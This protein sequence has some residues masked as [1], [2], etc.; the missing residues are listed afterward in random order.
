MIWTIQKKILAGFLA[1]LVLVLGISV[2]AM[3]QMSVL[4][5]ETTQIGEG[6]LP[7]VEL[8]GLIRAKFNRFRTLQLRYLLI[9]TQADR[10]FT[11]DKL[12][13]VETDINKAMERLESLLVTVEGRR[14]FGEFKRLFQEYRSQHAQVQTLLSER[15]EGEARK[16]LMVD[17]LKT[18]DEGVNLLEQLTAI[19]VDGGKE[20]VASA[21]N[22]YHTSRLLMIVVSLIIVGLGVGVSLWLSSR[23]SK[24]LIR[25]VE[26][27]K[28]LSQGVLTEKVEVTTNDESGQL[29]NAMNEMTDYLK[30]MARISDRL[31]AGDLSAQVQPKSAQDTFGVSFKQMI[32]NLTEMAAV[33]D[34]IASGDLSVQV[35]PKS[36]RDSF[37]IS[38][39]QMIANLRESLS[40]IGQGSSQVA[41]TSAQVASIG[42]LS[43]T[44]SQTLSSSSEEIT[45]TVHEM[46]SSIRQVAS[47]AQNQSAAATQTSAAITQMVAGLRGIAENA[48]RLASL[49]SA[50]NNAAERG[51]YTL[52]SAAQKLTQ[53]GSSV[54]SAGQT[55]NR[56][57]ERAESIGNIVETIDDIADQ[58][59]LLALNAAIEAARAGEHGLGFA[60]VAD[61]VRKLAERSA[62]STKEIGTL[63]NSIQL[64]SR[65]AVDQMEHSNQTVKEYM[66][67]SS[68]KDALTIIL[69]SAQQI[70]IATQE[71]ETA[72]SEQSAGAEQVAKAAQDL[73]R[74]TQEIHAATDEQSVGA[75]EVVRAVEQ[76]RDLVQQ[77]VQMASELQGSAE[78]LRQ[79]SSTLDRVVD[80]FKVGDRNGASSVAPPLSKSSAP[81]PAFV[82]NTVH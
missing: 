74:L 67:D 23:I 59:N 15:N 21:A 55:I 42:K 52:E 81:Y 58:T 56:L 30:E 22:V 14:L 28:Q 44:A 80:N 47:N 3:R 57:G 10:A 35:E 43:M 75:E 2:F 65:A 50:S 41:A 7:R 76:M 29:V 17:S 45:A 68:V 49:T 48:K 12:R 34:K 32:A 6:W 16:I 25:A 82:H 18:F 8:T 36:T 54:E 27:A 77:S 37:C 31:A 5:E 24:P 19:N 63:I 62:R 64:E 33:A 53:I 66:T 69:S 4:N 51:Q 11:A 9:A 70:A 46:A 60:V 73:T 72:T 78:N 26:T 39:K 13:D 1:V 38:F 20:G 40:R 79:Q 61:E 71:I